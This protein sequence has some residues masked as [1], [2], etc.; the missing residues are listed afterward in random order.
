[1]NSFRLILVTGLIALGVSACGGGGSSGSS[2]DATTKAPI[3][4]KIKGTIVGLTDGSAGLTLQFNAG[5][6]KTYTSAGEFEFDN[7]LTTGKPYRVTI[8]TQPVPPVVAEGATAL[9]AQ[10][11]GV[12]KGRGVVGYDDITDIVVTCETET[13]TQVNAHAQAEANYSAPKV[14]FDD[15]GD[16]LSVWQADVGDAKRLMVSLY[17]QSA[18]ETTKSWKP[19]TYLDESTQTGAWS[20]MD[21]IQLA[22][23]ATGYAVAW[24]MPGTDNVKQLHTRV[25]VKSPSGWS[26]KTSHITDATDVT[27]YTLASNGAQYM[28]VW[29]QTDF[30]AQLYTDAW[31]TRQLAATTPVSTTLTDKT[32]VPV[33][34]GNAEEFRLAWNINEDI[35][36]GMGS[37][38]QRQAIHTSSYRF[39]NNAWDTL[40]TLV[41]RV[42]NGEAPRLVVNATGFA[43]AFQYTSTL[44]NEPI[45][46]LQVLLSSV[47][48]KKDQ[49]CKSDKGRATDIQ[50]M[51]GTADYLL[52]WRDAADGSVNTLRCTVTASK[53]VLPLPGLSDGPAL[54]N[55]LTAT[56]DGATH[57]VAWQQPAADL[58]RGVY[59]ATFNESKLPNWTYAPQGPL[60]AASATLVA[61][62]ATFAHSAWAQWDDGK[63]TYTPRISTW[64]TTN[65]KWNDAITLTQTAQTIAPKNVRMIA[66]D[67]AERLAVWEQPLVNPSD[68]TLKSVVYA[69]VQNKGAWGTPEILPGKIEDTRI[70]TD[71]DSLGVVWLDRSVDNG[72]LWTRRATRGADDTMAWQNAEKILALTDPATLDMTTLASASNG[73]GLMIAWVQTAADATHSLTT[74]TYENNHWNAVEETQK[75]IET[76]IAVSSNGLGYALAWVEKVGDLRKVRARLHDGK[77]WGDAHD[78]GE[79]G[80]LEMAVGSTL[81]AANLALT[82][83]GD[84]YAVAWLRTANGKAA[85]KM[86]MSDAQQFTGLINILQNADGLAA[87]YLVAKGTEYGLV[88]QKMVEN[89]YTTYQRTY[90][91]NGWSDEAVLNGPSNA[92][93]IGVQSNGDDYLAIWQLAGDL[94]STA[95]ALLRQ[96][97]PPGEITSTRFGVSA[98][99]YTLAWTQTASAAAETDVTAPQKR[100]VWARTGF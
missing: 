12:A 60:P 92:P 71:G 17:N 61:S 51:A 70:L 55:T 74:L 57:S 76:E 24:V 68:A 35:D 23:S 42:D 67:H 98:N 58:S 82:T 29:Q 31:Q 79:V 37:T 38:V 49:T 44:D 72:G 46:N 25:Y 83:N 27:A 80:P 62:G 10:R 22:K 100:G 93:L 99:R 30:Y 69:S 32:V 78:V 4:A 20:Y 66:N 14:I 34:A 19:E 56:T 84:T 52:A 13:L 96:G 65:T 45:N 41:Q 7:T 63:K 48:L 26:D 39:A 64:D 47:S 50:L 40:N 53:K 21:N 85:L 88:W 2:A 75:N 54:L 9:P 16:G 6:D 33:L 90:T 97:S 87:P 59:T 11:C 81:P 91:S 5:G 77:T 18:T 73:R 1:M 28:I 3:D 89:N 86:R 94:A 95:S 8:K 15:A 43:L 36:N